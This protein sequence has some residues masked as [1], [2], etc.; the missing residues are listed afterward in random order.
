M[1]TQD[2]VEARRTIVADLLLNGWTGTRIAKHVKVHFTTVYEDIKAIREQW[3]QN[4]THSYGEWVEAELQK[5]DDLESKIAHRVDTGDLN[6]VNTRLK[7]QERRA[8]YLGLD[9]P[10][11]FVFEDS[12][13]AE[14]RELA[15]QVGMLDSPAVQKILNAN[16]D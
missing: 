7:I 10:T 15:E 1:A 6:A 5:L 9:S 4:Q 11:R 12:L 8:K 2:E 14:I 13:T 16:P 3:S